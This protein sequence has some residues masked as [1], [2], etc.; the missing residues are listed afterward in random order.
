MPLNL[1]NYTSKLKSPKKPSK[2]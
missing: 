1:T 2:K